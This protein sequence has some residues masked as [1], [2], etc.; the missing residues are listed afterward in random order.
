MICIAMRERA[1]RSAS[2]LTP[3]QQFVTLYSTPLPSITIPTANLQP[4]PR[5]ASDTML[6][7]SVSLAVAPLVLARY[8]RQSG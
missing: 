5:R 2:L 3:T 7:A 8:S 4:S 1:S 6:P